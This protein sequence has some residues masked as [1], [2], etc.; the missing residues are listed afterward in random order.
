MTL[1]IRTHALTNEVH[2]SFLI[3]DKPIKPTAENCVLHPVDGVAVKER[4]VHHSLKNKQSKGDWACLKNTNKII[5]KKLVYSCKCEPLIEEAKKMSK[6]L[7]PK[8][9]QIVAY[10]SGYLLFP[11]QAHQNPLSTE[12]L[13]LA[14]TIFM[15]LT[16]LGQVWFLRT[17]KVRQDCSRCSKRCALVM[18]RRCPVG[19]LAG[20]LG[21]DS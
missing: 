7:I 18:Q 10:Y 17:L 12:W 19:K 20:I 4:E 1:T 13:L 11:G 15:S 8:D 2:F 21:R 9:S 14:P 6:W 16:A 3:L 5:I